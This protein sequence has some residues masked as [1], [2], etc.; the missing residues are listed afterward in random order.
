MWK[1]FC[2]F[3]FDFRQNFEVRTFS[4]WLSIRRTKF[5]LNDHMILLDGFLNGFSKIQLFKVEICILIRDFWVILENYSMC[6][7]SICGNDIIAHWAYEETISSHTEHMLN[8][9]SR[10]L[11]QGKNSFCMNSYAEQTGKW[12]Y[13][14]LSIRG[15]DLSHPEHTRKCLKVEYLGEWNTI[16]VLQVLG[17]IKIRFLQKSI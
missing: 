8:K 17:T 7:L 11:S 15:N 6:M 4:R 13:R 3:S 5:F 16:F 12:F 10:M 9:F 1:N 2:F 14:T